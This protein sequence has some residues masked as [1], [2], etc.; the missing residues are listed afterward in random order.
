M[1][2]TL[3]CLFVCLFLSGERE[4]G[5]RAEIKQIVRILVLGWL[6]WEMKGQ[7][8]M[9]VKKERQYSGHLQCFLLSILILSQ[10][11]SDNVDLFVVSYN[12]R[13]V[14]TT[15][16][17]SVIGILRGIELNLCMSWVL[18][19]FN[20]IKSSNPWIHYIFSIIYI[21]NFFQQWFNFSCANFCLLG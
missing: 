10:D 17:K 1:H 7:V 9:L 2:T 8:R 14:F 15:S 20:N 13:M 16:L 18:K 12:L 5:N 6:T 21:F 19:Y 11:C 4:C 3:S